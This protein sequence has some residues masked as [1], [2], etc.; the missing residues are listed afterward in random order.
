MLLVYLLCTY[1]V[2]YQEL[3]D[4]ETFH[5]D[6]E[7]LSPTE[8][9]TQLPPLGEDL[10]LVAPSPEPQWVSSAAGISS[11][12]KRWGSFSD[13]E[14]T[15]LNANSD[16]IEKVF[17]SA[18]IDGRHTKGSTT[19]DLPFSRKRSSVSSVSGSKSG[20]SSSRRADDELQQKL[21]KRLIKE[22]DTH[23]LEKFESA[24]QQNMS[25]NRAIA[26][27]KHAPVS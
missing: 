25:Q 22:T 26:G 18:T 12:R 17:K 9:P 10:P 14:T 7:F 15:K 20:E 3:T 19:Y 6:K 1:N 27:T 23:A 4:E 2:N 11:N 24:V 21:N 13:S 8:L 16:Q 5:K